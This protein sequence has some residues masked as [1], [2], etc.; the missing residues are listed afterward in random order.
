MRIKSKIALIIG[1]AFFCQSALATTQNFQVVENY[2]MS[3]QSSFSQQDIKNVF[4][5][6]IY[7]ITVEWNQKDPKFK[8]QAV[9]SLNNELTILMENGVA[10]ED[11]QMY[12]ADSILD[13]S[14]RK[15]YKE[16]NQFLVAQG[17]TP[18]ERAMATIQFLEDIESSGATFTSSM[19]GNG[20]TYVVIVLLFVAVAYL[21]I[22]RIEF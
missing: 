5:R 20:R 18:K 4:D 22:N 11:I 21:N 2:T 1:L 10:P 13:P 9:E 3:E 8:D 7:E 15:E 14:S 17:K 6:F 12:L 16:L 19:N